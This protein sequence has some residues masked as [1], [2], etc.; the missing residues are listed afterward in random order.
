MAAVDQVGVVVVSG[1]GVAEV[2]PTLAVLGVDAHAVATGARVRRRA[3]LGLL[4]RLVSVAR[5]G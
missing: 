2:A 5:V 4:A 3:P 1:G